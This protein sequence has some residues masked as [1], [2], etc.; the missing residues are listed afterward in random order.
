MGLTHRYYDD[1]NGIR[2]HTAE[3]GEGPPVIL[4]H[5]FPELWYTWRH[6]MPALAEAGYRVIAPD[7][8][9]AGETTAPLDV[10]G[11]APQNQ[12]ADILSLMDRLGLEQA[13]VIG[14]DWGSVL[15]WNLA[16]HHGDRLN[17]VGG[18]NAP[19][20]QMLQAPVNLL[21]LLA[22]APGIWDYQFYFQ[23]PGIAEAEFEADVARFHTLLRRSSRPE[24]GFDILRDFHSV[25]ARGGLLVGYPQAPARSAIMSEADLEVYVRNYRR[26]GFRGM[27]N[28]YRVYDQLAAWAGDLQGRTVD[29]PVF[30][31]TCGK[32][33][34]MRPE[35]T[36]GMEALAPNLTRGHIEDCAHWSTEEQPDAVN[37]MLVEWLAKVLPA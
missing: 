20:L 1:I 2:M 18:I 13:T 7:L 29:I 12:C 16:F 17:A 34:V 27:L 23:E 30:V 31:L 26:T 4:C 36:A 37:R 32:D 14:H 5:G 19:G 22:A 15:A 33:P 25:R 6:Q 10:A 3:V 9:G 21:T 28:Y 35:L 11:Y 8:R 24:D